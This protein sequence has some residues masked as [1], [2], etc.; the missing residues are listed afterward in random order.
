MKLL[1]AY[2]NGNYKVYMFDDGTKI[3]ANKLSSLRPVFP[4][5]I[6]MKIS[7]RCDMGCPMC[8]EQSVP[9]GELA[10]LSHPIL[11]SLHPFTELALGGG[12]VLE[13]P[14]LNSFLKKMSNKGVLCNLTVHLHHYIKA[15][16]RLVSL[17][18]RK[19][20]H[21]LGVSV[22]EPLSEPLASSIAKFPNAVVHVIAGVVTQETLESMYDRDMKLL[23]LGYKNYGRGE[24][25]LTNHPSVNEQI[26]KLKD[27]LPELSKHF[28]LISFDNLALE[29][30]NVK[31]LVPEESWE[32]G[33]MGEDGQFTMYI[34]LVKEEY[35]VS[36]T[37]P[38]KPLT[39]DNIDDVFADIKVQRQ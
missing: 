31:Q 15:Y 19:L 26:N 17:S 4:E 34:D 30:L 1:G 37:S 23:I 13:H 36:S 16:D 21:G 32:M 20:I 9:D 18:K 35:A 8:H 7:N 22:S 6:D 24:N 27:L 3:R 11:D 28:A 2:K 25:Y 5:S 38:R 14:D 10:D 39:Q 33:Y 12:N 29:Q